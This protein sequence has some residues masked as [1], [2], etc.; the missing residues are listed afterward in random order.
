MDAMAATNS[1]L[2]DERLFK[3][4][5]VRKGGLQ[6]GRKERLSSLS[7]R[8]VVVFVEQPRISPK[9]LANL[10]LCERVRRLRR[11]V[12]MLVAQTVESIS[13]ISSEKLVGAFAGQD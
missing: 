11:S 7:M 1:I 13:H 2:I 6:R 4:I 9:L 10:R 12:R 3:T 5:E 8:I